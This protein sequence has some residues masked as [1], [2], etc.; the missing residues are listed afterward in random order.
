MLQ[1]LP[2]ERQRNRPS[3]HLLHEQS[4][5]LG[6]QRHAVMLA[7]EGQRLVAGEGQLV[8]A[9]LQDLAAHAPAHQRRQLQRVARG[10]DQ[11]QIGRRAGNE[12]IQHAERLA[13]A[14]QQVGIVQN[15]EQRLGRRLSLRLG[16]DLAQQRIDDRGPHLD[17]GAGPLPLFEKGQG[18]VGDAG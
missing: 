1:P 2:D 17:A 5:L 13:A 8:L 18:M 3:L 10:K 6:A 14:V 12:A 7:K 15:E 9:Y 16:G 4:G 11:A